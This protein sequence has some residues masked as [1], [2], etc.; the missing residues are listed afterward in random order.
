LKSSRANCR[1]LFDELGESGVV[2]RGTGKV[3]RSFGCI[4]GVVKIALAKLTVCI[5]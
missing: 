2:W 5:K 1:V 3:F 4:K